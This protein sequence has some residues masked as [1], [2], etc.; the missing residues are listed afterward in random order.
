M[1]LDPFFQQK[2]D[3]L[4][5]AVSRSVGRRALPNW[6]EKHLKS[7]KNVLDN[8]SFKDHE[9]QI[10][11]LRTEASHLVVRKSSQVGLSELIARLLLGLASLFPGTHW[12]YALPSTNF[13]RKFSAARVKPV[14]EAS[15]LLVGMLHKDASSNEMIRIGNS[16][17]YFT[18]AQRASQGISVPCRG[19]VRDERDFMSQMVA[20][21][22]ESRLT[23]NAPDEKVLCDFSTPTLP[24]YGVDELHAKG[25]GNVYMV[26]H[27]ACNHWTEVDPVFDI[28]IPGFDGGSLYNFTKGDLEDPRTLV[29]KAW[30]RCRHC[31][32]EISRQ[33]LADPAKRAWVP[34]RPDAD[35]KSFYVSP[36][37]VP[38]YNT[39]PVILQ[40]LSRY[41]RPDDWI[42]FG[43]GHAFQSAESSVMPQALKQAETGRFIQPGSVAVYGASL[44]IDVGKVSH[45]IALHPTGGKLEVLFA[46][47]IRQG[48]TADDP[49]KAK[50][51]DDQLTATALLRAKQFGALR[52]VIDA[53][54]DVTVP[55][56]VI[57]RSYYHQFWA[58]YFVRT[59]KDTKNFSLDEVKQI[60]NIA[61]TKMIDSLVK[62]INGGKIILPAGHP[63]TEVIKNHLQNWKRVSR[64]SDTTGE[65]VEAWVATGED[66]Y[67]MALLY[68][69]T[70]NLMAREGAAS[71]I[72]LPTNAMIQKVRVGGA[73]Q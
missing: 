70:A 34:Y 50:L 2:L 7:P 39:P 8:W 41:E 49:D 24:G 1:A 57:D 71:V 42:N 26:M 36:L 44:G 51:A 29:S 9:Y 52:G 20:T 32:R 66:H 15:E 12:I 14:I 53:A 63:E 46:E 73:L 72:A 11:I 35:I 18:G 16:F 64:M 31:G 6:M 58:S 47:R 69:Y 62:D 65:R 30:V 61:R 56:R 27:E 3:T 23:H 10:D 60:V 22:F 59:I 17:L 28:V 33:N 48:T 67:A 54:P 37:D 5:V 25:T 43:L 45:L 68:A 40:G 21:T 13:A 38:A 55:A 4:A 19:L